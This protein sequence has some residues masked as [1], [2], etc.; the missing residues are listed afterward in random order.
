MSS[1]SEYTRGLTNSELSLT[2]EQQ[3]DRLSTS[4]LL[5]INLFMSNSEQDELLDKLHEGLQRE[6]QKGTEIAQELDLQ[7][8]LIDRVDGKIDK[9]NHRVKRATTGVERLIKKNKCNCALYL[10]IILLIIIL[11]AMVS[12]NNFGMGFPS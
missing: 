6:H 9:Q 2:F 7:E 11:I 3:M 10:L 1:E 5:N 4:L 8:R 12:T